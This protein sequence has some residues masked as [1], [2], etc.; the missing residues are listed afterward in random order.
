MSLLEKK[1]RNEDQDEEPQVNDEESQ[2]NDEESQV[3]DEESQVNDEDPQVNDE[4]SQ[5]NDEE[6]Q[7]YEEE[8]Q[9]YEEEDQDYDQESSATLEIDSDGDREYVPR[10]SSILTESEVDSPEVIEKEVQEIFRRHNVPE[11]NEEEL[12]DDQEDFSE[13]EDTS[14]MTVAEKQRRA[15]EFLKDNKYNRFFK[16]QAPAEFM[17]NTESEAKIQLRIRFLLQYEQFVREHQGDTEAIKKWVRKWRPSKTER[18][19]AGGELRKWKKSVLKHYHL[20]IDNE[21]T[22]DVLLG[23]NV[24]QRR[25]RDSHGNYHERD[26]HYLRSHDIQVLLGKSDIPCFLNWAHE[27]KHFG[28]NTDV[29]E[30]QW[31]SLE[32]N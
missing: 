28:K 27:N 5:V 11:E 7:D 29:S 18:S 17:S 23:K 32:R 19:S 30:T 22:M 2:V 31:G 25:K 15:R 26:T 4:E 16:G 12:Q 10:R 24:I 21:E 9:D 8:D 1:K 14:D 3:N 13:D 20:Y 6:D